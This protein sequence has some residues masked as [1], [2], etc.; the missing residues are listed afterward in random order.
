MSRKGFWVSVLFLLAMGLTIQATAATYTINSFGLNHRHYEDGRQLNRLYLDIRDESKNYPSSDMLEACTLYDP[1]GKIVA[2]SDF[3]FYTERELDGY[4]NGDYGQWSYQTA[5]YTPRTYTGI[6]AASLVPGTYRLVVTF[7]GATSEKTLTYNGDVK[8]PVVKGAKIKARIDTHGDLLCDWPVFYDLAR[9]NPGLTTSARPF[10]EI[11]KGTLFVGTVYIRVPFHLGRLYV[12]KAV[13][14]LM[15]K[16]GDNFKICIRLQTYDG[17][18]R[19]YSNKPVLRLTAKGKVAL[20]EDVDMD[21]TDEERF[22]P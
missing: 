6:V 19:T 20:L 5:F 17:T 22:D 4:Y 1:V 21:S 3:K 12:P 11:Y 18:V 8:I 13:L 15:K 10:I 2:I 7:A 9:T 14:N 16:E